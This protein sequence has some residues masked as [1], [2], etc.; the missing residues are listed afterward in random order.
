[1]K[2]NNQSKHPSFHHT[3]GKEARI[4]VAHFSRCY[5]I[6]VR[7]VTLGKSHTDRSEASQVIMHVSDVNPKMLSVT[8]TNCRIHLCCR[9]ET[10]LR[11]KDRKRMQAHGTG[12]GP[13]TCKTWNIY[14][15]NSSRKKRY[16]RSRNYPTLTKTGIYPHAPLLLS[17]INQPPINPTKSA[18]PVTPNRIAALRLSLTSLCNQCCLN[19]NLPNRI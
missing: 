19:L 2:E 11:K 10:W 12:T 7:L 6:S 9:I 3:A 18:I 14:K 1:M 16:H 13:I 5:P 17:F 15:W 4:Q 8:S